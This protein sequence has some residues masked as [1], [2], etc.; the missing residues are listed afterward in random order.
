VDA[1]ANVGVILGGFLVY[2]FNSHVPD[3]LIGFAIALIVI[4]GGISIIKDASK[5]SLHA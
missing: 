5:E 1:I 3:L 2:L 4:R